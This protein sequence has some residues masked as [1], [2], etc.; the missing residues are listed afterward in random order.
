MY[1]GSGRSRNAVR[2]AIGN[3][4]EAYVT[5]KNGQDGGLLLFSQ[6]GAAST[7]AR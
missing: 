2:T 5:G 6:H 3:V 7:M 1:R 4:G